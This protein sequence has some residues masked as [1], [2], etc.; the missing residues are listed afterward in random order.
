MSQKEAKLFQEVPYS[1]EKIHRYTLTE[2]SNI[3]I[4]ESSLS[5]ANIM[6]STLIGL[7]TKIDQYARLGLPLHPSH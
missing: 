7:T 1:A 4:E 6:L 5:L 2:Q 3:L